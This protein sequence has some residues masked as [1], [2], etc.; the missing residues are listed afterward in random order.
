[1]LR[2]GAHRRE[3]AEDVVE[4]DVVV[5][6]VPLEAALCDERLVQFVVVA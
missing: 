1:V 5:E 4:P 3:D 6:E 2:A